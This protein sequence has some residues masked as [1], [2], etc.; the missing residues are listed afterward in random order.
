MIYAG[1]PS[2]HLSAMKR[3]GTWPLKI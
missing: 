1:M 3:Y 2:G